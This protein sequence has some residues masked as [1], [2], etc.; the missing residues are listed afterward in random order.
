MFM[1]LDFSAPDKLIV[2]TVLH[3]YYVV[4]YENSLIKTADLGPIQRKSVENLQ[5]KRLTS[6]YFCRQSKKNGRCIPTSFPADVG[7]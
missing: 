6:I 2:Y 3:M 1:C 4:Q 7:L 5:G